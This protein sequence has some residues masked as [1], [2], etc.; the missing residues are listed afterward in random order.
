MQIDLELIV[1]QDSLGDTA[2]PLAVQ[3]DGES[4]SNTNSYVVNSP[5]DT[6]CISSKNFLYQG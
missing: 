5:V 4:P 3:D 1:L 2:V 6:D